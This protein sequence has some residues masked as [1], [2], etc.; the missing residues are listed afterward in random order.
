MG[1]DHPSKSMAF[2]RAVA[3]EDL[4]ALHAHQTWP[5][6]EQ[7]VTMDLFRFVDDRKIVENWYSKMRSP[8]KQRM[9]IQYSKKILNDNRFDVSLAW[10][11]E[12]IRS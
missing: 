9:E 7:C 1:R 5:G 4:V 8:V 6:D 3:E 11:S 2:V 12:R 10:L